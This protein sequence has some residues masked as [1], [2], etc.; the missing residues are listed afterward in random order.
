MP[1]RRGKRYFK[2][3]LRDIYKYARGKGKSKKKAAAMAVAA[4][5]RLIRKKRRRS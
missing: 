4:A 5:Y 3:N 2:S 1:L